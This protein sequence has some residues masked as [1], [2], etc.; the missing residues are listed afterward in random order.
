MG[1]SLVVVGCF[2]LF[3]EVDLVFLVGFDSELVLVESVS[4]FL[5][6]MVSWVCWYFRLLVTDDG[7]QIL[8]MA[9]LEMISTPI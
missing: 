2:E 8:I 3:V 7:L 6:H 1:G 5:L 4:R 9:P